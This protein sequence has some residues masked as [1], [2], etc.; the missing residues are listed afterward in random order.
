MVWSVPYVSYHTWFGVSFVFA[1]LHH[2]LLDACPTALDHVVEH[3]AELGV[4]ACL[5]WSIYLRCGQRMQN[6]TRYKIKV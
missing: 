6:T 1:G 3:R 2:L 5:V 4:L